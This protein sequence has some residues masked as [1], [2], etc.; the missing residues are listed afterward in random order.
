MIEDWDWG[1]YYQYHIYELDVTTGETTLV[2]TIEDIPSPQKVEFISA[3]TMVIWDQ[4]EDYIYTASLDEIEYG[5]LTCNQFVWAQG[6]IASN[7]HL[8]MAYNKEL[9]LVF[10]ATVDEW[11]INDGK[12]GLFMLD[13][14]KKTIKKV[15]D[16][17]YDLDM[18]DL[19]FIQ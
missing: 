6:L 1:E 12:L 7:Y 10:I 15:A 18:I 17:A 9:D 8:A 4:M 2:A 5:Y 19:V 11:G 3:D 16:T 13:P 14:N